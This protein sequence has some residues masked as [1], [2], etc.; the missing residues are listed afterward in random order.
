[1]NKSIIKQI[2]AV[3]TALFFVVTAAYA[4]PTITLIEKST[5]ANNQTEIMVNLSGLSDTD[6]G[7]LNASGTA[8]TIETD[9]GM[10]IVPGSVQSSF[11]DTFVNQF[12]KAGTDPNSYTVPVEGYN[13]PLVFNNDGATKMMIAAARCTPTDN[14]TENELM[15]FKVEGDATGNVTIQPTVLNNPDAG[16]PVD[17]K[18]DVLVGSDPAEGASDPYPVKISADMP[19][20]SI[21]VERGGTTDTDSDGLVDSVE[22]GTGIFVDANNTGTDPNKADT[23][24]DGVK[25]GQEV[26]DGTDPNDPNDFKV[27]LAKGD[28]N[29]DGNVDIFD[30][31][32]VAQY[33]ALM[34]SQSDLAGFSVADADCS[35]NVDI[36]DA[37]RIAQ[38]DALMISN[39][40]CP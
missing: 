19:P 33:D 15:T 22:T 32:I 2:L 18:I 16:Y 3:I 37:L 20:K 28:A 11:F 34:K 17:T 14:S 25:D 35:G 9:G 4:E 24:G 13:K 38:F 27:T 5:D 40:D 36:F 31:L 7:H 21:T 30:A 29:G 1:M 6:R 12:N 8:F 39:L 23:D 10:T 26:I